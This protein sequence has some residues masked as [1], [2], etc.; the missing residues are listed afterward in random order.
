MKLNHITFSIFAVCFVLF[1]IHSIEFIKSNRELSS[2]QI[3]KTQLS[4][5]LIKLRIKQ[6][7]KNIQTKP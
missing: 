2:L 3:E 1:I 7:Q 6:Q 5:D 4:I